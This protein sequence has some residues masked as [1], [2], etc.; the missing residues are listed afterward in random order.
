MF[1]ILDLDNYSV[2]DTNISGHKGVE[3]KGWVRIITV[4]AQTTE[5][6]DTQGFHQDTWLSDERI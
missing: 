6:H 2:Y 4:F 1:N 5:F 3:L